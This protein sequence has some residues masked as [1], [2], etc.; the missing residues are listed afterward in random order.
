MNSADGDFT[1]DTLENDT[2]GNLTLYF[3][4]LRPGGPGNADVYASAMGNDGTF[5]PAVLVPELSS[6]A[7]D[8]YAVPRRDGLELFLVSN[9]DGT[10][11]AND[12]WA[13][14]RERTSDPWS[15]PIN[16]G[17][18]INTTAVDDGPAISSS[19]TDLIFFSTRPGGLGSEDLYTITR[20]K[21]PL[22]TAECAVTGTPAISAMVNSG[23]FQ[24][25]ISANAM[26]SIFGSGF[27]PQGTSRV[28]GRLGLNETRFPTELACVA[29]AVAGLRAPVTFVSGNQINAQLPSL[30]I[31][32]PVEIRV[33]LNPGRPNEIRGAST[34]VP[35]QARSP[36]F[37]TFTGST[38]AAQHTNFAPLA[39]PAVIPAGRPARPGD[40][41]ILYGTGFGLTVPAFQAGEIADR[42][43]LLRDAISVT[44]GGVALR[45]ENILYAGL[46]PGSISGLYQFNVRIPETVR[47]GDAPVVIEVGGARTQTGLTIPVR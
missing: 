30:T 29:L 18:S 46:A 37:F 17:P 16:L 1:P 5:G 6:S 7:N 27:A 10:L 23:S 15:P 4:S 13:S 20:A 8:W 25:G 47:A 12:L 2:T 28:V 38:I 43:A 21:A 34:N 26:V 36:A 32:G 44:I 40:S 31:T 39:D 42:T 9:R 19:G 14:T 41:I 22:P 35:I 24:P 33:I 3:A 45:P 11:G